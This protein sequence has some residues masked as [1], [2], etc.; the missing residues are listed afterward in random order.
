[1]DV[2]YEQLVELA[3]AD[4]RMVGLILTGSR[5]RR[6]AAS[7]ASDWDVRL[8]VRDE[9][10]EGCRQELATPRG[11][12]VEV[13]VLGLGDLERIGEFGTES[14][15]DRYSYVDVTVEVDDAEGSVAALV[16]SLSVLREDEAHALAAAR[17]DDFVNA[18]YRAAKNFRSGLELESRLD[19]AESV[20]P[21][22]DFLFA[23]HLRV[24]PF[25]RFLR[26]ELDRCPLPGAPWAAD[27]LLPRLAAVIAG[28][29]G[30]QQRTFRH[31]EELARVQG[32]GEVI[33]SWEPDV[34]RLRGDADESPT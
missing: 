10:I 30:A 16:R 2:T 22:L 23:A 24:R 33:D 3:R 12:P 32:F 4:E 11:S 34:S 19:A 6:F 14:A 29:L 15:W 5:G 1:M 20:S 17:L 25:N 31:V 26:W 13:V 9:A 28:D 8:V 7:E 27:A 21:L 18:Y